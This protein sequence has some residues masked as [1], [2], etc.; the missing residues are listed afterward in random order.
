MI[1]SESMLGIL[2]VFIWPLS[3]PTLPY[4]SHLQ[5]PLTR[6][7][8]IKF[9]GRGCLPP[10]AFGTI[11]AFKVNEL[12]Y[13]IAYIQEH[14]SAILKKPCE[15]NRLWIEWI[16]DFM[17]TKDQVE[18]SDDWSRSIYRSIPE[19]MLCNRVVWHFV[20]LDDTRASIEFVQNQQSD[21]ISP[22]EIVRVNAKEKK[23]SQNSSS[24]RH[25]KGKIS[26]SLFC[27][28]LNGLKHNTLVNGWKRFRTSSSSFNVSDP[29]ITQQ[30]WE[31]RHLF[32]TGR[33]SAFQQQYLDVDNRQFFVCFLT[34]FLYQAIFT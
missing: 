32:S 33:T 31:I 26:S 14:L 25:F 24:A 22:D 8:A 11:R 34:Q 30:T 28:R 21:E 7:P 5:S 23:L 15:K 29:Y 9:L 3:D 6:I 13:T 12:R 2:G 18:S 20:D 27:L 19:I 16:L 10:T 17:K 4:D 1:E